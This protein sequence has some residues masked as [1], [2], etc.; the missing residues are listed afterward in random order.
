M[1]LQLVVSTTHI[2]FCISIRFDSMYMVVHFLSARGTVFGALYALNGFF[3]VVWLHNLV[4]NKPFIARKKLNGY[5]LNDAYQ[6]WRFS[7][8]TAPDMK[9]RSF[10]NSMLKFNHSMPIKS[11]RNNNLGF[12]ISKI[13]LPNL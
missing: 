8:T 7:D 9:K 13:A 3:L 10:A 2:G 5:T 4:F 1:R 12:S 6:I 11:A